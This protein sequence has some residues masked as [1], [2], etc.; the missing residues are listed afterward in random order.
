MNGFFNNLV[1]RHLGTCD[2]I[3]PRLSGRFETNKNSMP[4]ANGTITDITEN[5]QTLQTSGESF[6]TDSPIVTDRKADSAER[7]NNFSPL[8]H[9][10]QNQANTPT[11]P[12][13]I[14]TNFTRNNLAEKN[15]NNINSQLLSE[16]SKITDSLNGNKQSDHTFIKQSQKKQSTLLDNNRT[17][18]DHTGNKSDTL[19]K[20]MREKNALSRVS[21]SEGISESELNHRIQAMIQ[22]LTKDASSLDTSGNH[23]NKNNDDALVST[24]SKT[25]AP[26]L[27]S[28]IPPEN[29]SPVAKRKR[30]QEENNFSKNTDTPTNQSQLEPPSWL[31]DMASQLTQGLQ[32]TEQKADPVI[33]VTI[34]RVEVRAVQKD[35]PRKAQQTK[36]PNGV[37]TL[38]N[39]LKQRAGRNSK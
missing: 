20:I 19:D 28:T 37:M 39:Y 7:K 3:Q 35:E 1:N 30:I 15:I 33:N 32:N 18:H 31:A 13:T 36:K 14:K 2:T 23:N 5:E 22:H 8:S 10:D 29:L 27:D 11:E 6:F 24:L 26:Q 17:I 12:D 21:A 25:K 9:T 34:G 16:K 38:D 4:V